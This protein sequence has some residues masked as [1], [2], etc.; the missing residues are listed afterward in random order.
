[1]GFPIRQLLVT[2]GISLI[3]LPS[4]AVLFKS[5]GDPSYNTTA[6]GGLLA[7]SGW[8]YEGEWNSYLGT[9]IAPN[10]FIT[11]S[12]F[13]GNT[14]WIFFLNGAEYHPVASFKDPDSDLIL[15]QVAE[16]FPWYAPLYAASNETGKRCV[17]FGWGTER[18]SAVVV[19]GVTNG[20]AWGP[21]DGRLRW[22][23]NKIAAVVAGGSGL[24]DFLRADFSRQGGAN[25]CHLSFGDSGGA[26]FIQDGNK[27]WRL[28]GIHYSVDEPLIS[29]NGVNDSGFNAAMLDYGGVYRGGD[30]SWA[31]VANQISDIPASFYSTRISSRIAWINS[32]ISN[33]LSNPPVVHDLA[34]VKLKAPRRITLT[35][36]RLS[37]TGK[38]TVTIQNLGTQTEIIPDLETLNNL[39][40]LDVV[41]LGTNCPDKA[42]MLVPPAKGFP[43][44]V[45]PKKRLKLT[46][47]AL[48]DCA[49]DP[50]ATSQNAAHDDFETT[51]TVDLGAL[52]ETDDG[53][54]NNVC[55]RSPGPNDPGCG[56]KDPLTRQ[57]GAA[58]V[59]DVVWKR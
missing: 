11:A 34:V 28:A 43:L 52:G 39:V 23:E 7:G 58:V 8:A 59:T 12:H 54:S 27:V 19:G 6:P 42:A 24:G 25:E 5:T 48:F 32:V 26:M 20:W 18:G 14:G 4:H 31:L 46:Y 15:W 22:G 50:L 57:S 1:L 44:A 40:K 3:G 30:G 41:S 36:S 37:S 9:P 55:P 45:G 47:Q 21:G 29:T 13:G 2:A 56:S 38:L 33:N 53:V 10:Y 49:N 17:V 35:A 16:T 51:A